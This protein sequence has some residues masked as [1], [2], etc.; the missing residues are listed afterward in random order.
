MHAR[1]PPAPAR[2]GLSLIA[3]VSCFALARCNYDTT[4]YEPEVR[5]IAAA[6]LHCDAGD[7]QI[8]PVRDKHGTHIFVCDGCGCTATYDCAW[9]DYDSCDREPL[10]EPL[11]ASCR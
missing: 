8:T 9:D 1:I 6:E 5:K 3:F 7:I 2:L 10:L 11:D 4:D